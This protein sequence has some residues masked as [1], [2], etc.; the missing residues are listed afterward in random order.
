MLM[1]QDFLRTSLLKR[2]FIWIA[3]LYVVL[4]GTY[5]LFSRPIAEVMNA[6][7]YSADSL[8]ILIGVCVVAISSWSF[9]EARSQRKYFKK[10]NAIKEDTA[11]SGTY[12]LGTLYFMHFLCHFLALLVWFFTPDSF[13]GNLGNAGVGY[14]DIMIIW[15]IAMAA[16]EF[17]GRIFFTFF[18]FKETLVVTLNSLKFVLAELIIIYGFVLVMPLLMSGRL[19]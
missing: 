15:L 5:L 7:G 4:L 10:R 12:K 3:G 17:F 8:L 6:F 1:T 14:W 9:G 13:F 19:A 11:A 2:P 18:L 16:I